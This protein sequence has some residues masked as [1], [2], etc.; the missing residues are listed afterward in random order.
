MHTERMILTCKEARRQRGTKRG[1]RGTNGLL[2]PRP[3]PSRVD[4]TGNVSTTIVKIVHIRTN[5][6]V[7]DRV[8]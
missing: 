6:S 5:T 8:S 3:E 2:S 1:V 4:G 7:H